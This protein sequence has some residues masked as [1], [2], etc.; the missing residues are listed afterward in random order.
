[1][2]KIGSNPRAVLQMTVLRPLASELQGSNDGNTTVVCACLPKMTIQKGF[3][4]IELM[5]VV[6]IIGILAAIAIPAYQDY[7]VRT[8]VTEGLNFA[9]AAET[10]V[11]EGFQA[12]DINGVASASAA[13]ANNWAA[14]KYVANV[15]IN[16]ATG[17][18]TVQYGGAASP[19]QIAGKDIIL[20]PFASPAGGGPAIA[21]AAGSV[22]A[23]DWA[24]ASTGV[25]TAAAAGMAVAAGTVK[26][27]YAPSQCR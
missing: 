26:A 27:T 1:M 3:T 15:L 12:N 10:A 20:Y 22:G 19:P 8:K 7:T 11:A 4:L 5:I 24:C 25:T 13:W 9:A 6:A 23:I 17:V 2:S 16:A 14:T 18:I 21:L